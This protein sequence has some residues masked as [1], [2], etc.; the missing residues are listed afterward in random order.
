MVEFLAIG[1]VGLLPAFL[2]LLQALRTRN[3]AR[4]GYFHCYVASA[5][6][7]SVILILIRIADPL[8]FQKCYWPIQFITLILGYGIILEIL[9]HV[10]SP[11]PGVERFARLLGLATLAATCCFALVYPL[12]VPPPS[13]VGPYGEIERGVRAAQTILLICVLG[14]ISHYEIPLG[15]NMRGMILGYGL[16]V[17]TSLVGLALAAHAGTWLITVWRYAQ[18]IS[19]DISLLI[20]LVALWSYAPNP[21]PNADTHLEQDYDALVV[22]TK[23][24]IGVLRSHLFKAVRS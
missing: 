11:Y 6:F 18:P 15:R 3:L 1:T 22:R 5:V 8:L 14:V 24:V 12:I 21:V 7:G 23:V 2:I 20:W 19:F 13:H 17:A 16:Y 10:F 4:Y 9:R